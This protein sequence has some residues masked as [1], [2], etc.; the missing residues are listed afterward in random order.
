MKKFTVLC[1][2]FVMILTLGGCSKNQ[3]FKVRITAE[4]GSTAD[5]VYSDAEIS[6]TEGRIILRAGEGL[7]DTAVVLKPVSPDSDYTGKP[8]YL[9]PGASLTLEA[10]KGEWYKIGV[11]IQNP[12][13]TEKSVYVE[14]DNVEIRVS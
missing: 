14:V 2:L 10:K 5:F 9:T 8:E 1:A 3:E 6:P 12:S 13:D 7:G 4:P 11:S